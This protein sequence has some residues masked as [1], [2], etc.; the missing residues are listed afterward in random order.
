MYMKGKS[1]SDRL[2]KLP[3]LTELK[4]EP[5]STNHVFIKPKKAKTV[6]RKS[7]AKRGKVEAKG[8]IKK[9]Y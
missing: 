3:K 4:A 7:T 8:G 2:K 6:S 5:K 9:I 1:M